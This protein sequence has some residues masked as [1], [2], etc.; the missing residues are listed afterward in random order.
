[1]HTSW[2]NTFWKSESQAYLTSGR[3]AARPVYVLPREHADLQVLT[4]LVKLFVRIP[5]STFR[6]SSLEDTMVPGTARRRHVSRL[7][8]SNH[9]KADRAL[10]PIC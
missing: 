7:D 3:A 6:D 8:N 1:M 9:A 2:Q 10:L 5:R 4:P